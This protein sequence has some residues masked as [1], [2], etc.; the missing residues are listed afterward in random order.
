MQA[1]ERNENISFILDKIDWKARLFPLY[2]T[3]YNLVT[4]P[5]SWVFWAIM[6]PAKNSEFSAPKGERTLLDNL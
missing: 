2:S 5:Q 3:S 1:S 4:S 6:Y